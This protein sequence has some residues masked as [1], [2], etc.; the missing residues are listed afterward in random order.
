M[1]TSSMY[2]SQRQKGTEAVT[3]RCI[4][5]AKGALIWCLKVE[6]LGFLPRMMPGALQRREGRVV[7]LIE[8]T[9]VLWLACSPHEAVWK[10][11]VQR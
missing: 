3:L 11:Q 10:Q 8:L 2:L 5:P 9:R 7:L 4:P 6:L 1:Q